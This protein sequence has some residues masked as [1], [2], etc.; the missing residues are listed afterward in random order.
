MGFWWWFKNRFSKRFEIANV[1]NV[2][3]SKSIDASG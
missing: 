2:I 1:G 3:A